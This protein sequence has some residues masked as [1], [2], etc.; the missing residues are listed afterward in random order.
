MLPKLR[1]NLNLDYSEDILNNN[2]NKEMM[3]DIDK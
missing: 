2:T 3:L 1:R